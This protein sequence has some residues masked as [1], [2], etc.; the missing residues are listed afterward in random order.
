M[1][2]DATP[3]ATM[4]TKQIE[5]KDYMLHEEELMQR[6]M[7]ER[8]E[9]EV[10]VEAEMMLIKVTILATEDEGCKVVTQSFFGAEG[11]AVIEFPD[12]TIS[13]TFI[14]GA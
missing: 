7:T 14:R 3:S 13:F 10:E 4:L 5:Q 1:L 6:L 8:K 9:Q 2:M 11:N 12:S